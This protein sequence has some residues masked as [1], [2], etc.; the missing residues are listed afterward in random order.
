MEKLCSVSFRDLAAPILN[1]A[2]GKVF[3]SMLVRRLNWML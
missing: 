3:L 2:L 1:I